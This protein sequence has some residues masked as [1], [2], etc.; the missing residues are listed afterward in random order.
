MYY[1]GLGAGEAVKTEVLETK[2]P[3]GITPD[4]LKDIGGMVERGIRQYGET[5]TA[6]RQLKAKPAPQFMVPNLALDQGPVEERPKAQVLTP[7]ITLLSVGLILGG[8]IL[9]VMALAKRK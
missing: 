2:A 4:V 8:G 6:L 3:F 7:G 5:Q 9:L 1:S